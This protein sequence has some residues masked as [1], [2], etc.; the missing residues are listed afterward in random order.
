MRAVFEACGDGCEVSCEAR[1]DVYASVAANDCLRLDFSNL[2]GRDREVELPSERITVSESPG[3]GW[4]DVGG[5]IAGVM[6][7]LWC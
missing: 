1:E 5:G 7:G 4:L 2:G 3:V 6:R